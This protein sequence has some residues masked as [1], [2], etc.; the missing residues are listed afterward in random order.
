MSHVTSWQNAAVDV[1]VHAIEAGWFRI[2]TK[3][4]ENKEEE[5]HESPWSLK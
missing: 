3:L 4:T 2:I 1:T 5:I